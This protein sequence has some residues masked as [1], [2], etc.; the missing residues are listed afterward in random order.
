MEIIK[1]KPE[2][3]QA[4]EEVI[5]QVWRPTFLHRIDYTQLKYMEENMYTT[6]AFLQ[7]AEEEGHQF[8][9]AVENQQVLGFI[10]YLEKGNHYRIPKL[11]LSPKYH[12][13]G[14]GS[15]LIDAVKQL[16]VQAGKEFIELNINRYNRSLYFYRRYGFYIHASE[17]V[18]LGDFLLNDYILRLN[19]R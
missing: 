8:L 1:A 16:T 11:Y 2:H 19:V 18:Q 4:M 5:R 15:K 7:Q 10:S 12:G 9:V 14:I 3:F 6:E 17:D 13:R